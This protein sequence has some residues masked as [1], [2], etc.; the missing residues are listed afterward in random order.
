MPYENV[1]GYYSLLIA[2]S[3][4]KLSYRIISMHGRALRLVYRDYKATFEELLSKDNSVIIYYKNTQLCQGN[5][6]SK[7]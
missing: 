4:W 7:K 6:H 2:V 3:F 5:I 1:C